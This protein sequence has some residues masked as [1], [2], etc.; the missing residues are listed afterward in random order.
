MD[1]HTTP[2]QAPAPDSDAQSNAPAAPPPG[3]QH[4][5]AEVHQPYGAAPAGAYEPG[6][7]YTFQPPAHDTSPYP[8]SPIYA[9]TYSAPWGVT[10]PPAP[11]PRPT[12]GPV[13][14]AALAL[15]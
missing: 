3:Q 5:A 13:V 15:A 10:A 12:G 9:P 6:H 4:P 8:P 1:D 14:L 11:R 7:G 2:P